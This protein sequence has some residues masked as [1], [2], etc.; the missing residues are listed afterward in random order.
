M[1]IIED[2]SIVPGADSYISLD[3]ARAMAANYGVVLPEDDTKAEV[4]LRNGAIYIGLFEAQM[5]GS[6][7]SASQSLAYPRSGTA[8]NGFPVS[9]TTIPA[10]LKM[11]QIQA[12]ATYGAGTSVRSNTDGR[13][14]QTERVEGAVTVTYF[15]NGSNGS[16]TSITAA[17][18]A[19]KQILCGGSGGANNGLSFRMFRG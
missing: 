4:A 1:L 19:L 16:T 11:A 5:C 14:V 17:D 9:N 6:R 10:Q 7:V 2:G 13:S 12:A 15:N 8:I 18:D 3:D